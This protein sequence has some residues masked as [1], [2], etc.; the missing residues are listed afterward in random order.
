MTTKFHN[1]EREARLMCLDKAATPEERGCNLAYSAFVRAAQDLN[2]YLRQPKSVYDATRKGLLVQSCQIL[3][4]EEQFPVVKTVE[5]IVE[6]IVEKVVIKEVVKTVYRDIDGVLFHSTDILI[7]T[8][9]ERLAEA[10]GQVAAMAMQLEMGARERYKEMYFKHKSAETLINAQRDAFEVASNIMRIAEVVTRNLVVPSSTYVLDQGCQTDP[11]TL[12]VPTEIKA[13]AEPEPLQKKD[14]DEPDTNSASSASH[15]QIPFDSSASVLDMAVLRRLEAVEKELAEKKAFKAFKLEAQKEELEIIQKKQIKKQQKKIN[16]I[17]VE[18][19]RREKELEAERKRREEKFE[20][21]VQERR[22]KRARKAQRKVE[23]KAEQEAIVAAEK[24]A[25]ISRLAA[26]RSE[27]EVAVQDVLP[28]FKETILLDVYKIQKTH[29]DARRD[30]KNIIANFEN[31]LS[32]EASNRYENATRKIDQFERSIDNK[33]HDMQQGLKQ[34][35]LDLQRANHR[36]NVLVKS[37]NTTQS[38][39]VPITKIVQNI[40][41]DELDLLLEQIPSIQKQYSKAS[42]MNQTT[43]TKEKLSYFNPTKRMEYDS[44][45]TCDEWAFQKNI[46]RDLY[47]PIGVYVIVG[48]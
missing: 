12:E 8:L 39:P 25:N 2:L 41:K 9:Q 7:S 23:K 42:V 38:T 26:L 37:V 11:V 36:H 31:R 47:V 19:E 13:Q 43:F 4:P 28:I 44:R 35:N 40:I 24:E 5:K 27:M 45:M 10:Q 14:D 17:K 21:K 15:A 33:L 48:K 16:K 32:I 1:L 30:T 34:C 6:K 46:N 29:K 22:E 20:K 18:T 3:C